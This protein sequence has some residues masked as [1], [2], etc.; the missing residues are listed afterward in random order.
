M[1]ENILPVFSSRSFMV[2]CFK[3]KSLSHFKLIF[4]GGERVCSNCID[5][6]ACVSAFVS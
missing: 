3:F 2:S 4:V 6:Q 5:L 1:S